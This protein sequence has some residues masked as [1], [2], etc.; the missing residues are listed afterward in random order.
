MLT[1][2]RFSDEAGLAHLLREKCLSEDVVYLVRAR[3]VEVL[4]LE[5]YL[6]AAKRVRE[7][8]RVVEERRSA[9]IFFQQVVE[10]AD[11]IGVILVMLVF[12]FELV[13]TEEIAELD[14]K[15]DV[16]RLKLIATDGSTNYIR[17]K[18]DEMDEY[19]F[20]KWTE[21]H[22]ATCERQDIIG[23]SDHTLDILRKKQK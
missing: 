1:C 22:L 6:R 3:V 14:S 4:A 23:I 12:L 16:E 11:K 15:L 8:L 20:G 2:A 5:V 9:C 10:L 13:R 17:D 19:T 21:Y 7:L 18:I